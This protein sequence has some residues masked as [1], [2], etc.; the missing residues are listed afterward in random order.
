[1][2]IQKLPPQSIEAEKATLGCLLLKSDLIETSSMIFEDDFI[3]PSHRIIFR[4]IQSVIRKNLPVDI[5]TVSQQLMSEN[6]LENVG[7]AS[8]IS[9]LPDNI[10][11]TNNYSSYVEI[12]KEC[13]LRRKLIEV[14]NNIIAESYDRNI[15]LEEII[16]KVEQEILQVTAFD[17]KEKFHFLKDIILDILN[18][19]ETRKKSETA[20]TGIP[21]GYPTLDKITSGFEKGDLIIIAARPSVGKTTFAL[22]LAL[23]MAM[24]FDKIVG[25]FS[26]EMSAKMLGYKIIS[27]TAKISVNQI[28]K[29]DIVFADIQKL[30]DAVSLIFEKKI[31]FDEASSLTLFDIKQR[32]RRLKS[33]YGLDAIFVDYLQLISPPLNSKIENR[34]QI[35]SDISKGLKQLAK[36]L[37]I[38]VIA[39]AQLSRA[40]EKREDKRPQLSDLRESG[41][42]EQ[43]ADFVGFLYREDYYKSKKNENVDQESK[44]VTE[45]IIGKQRLGR[46]GDIIKFKFYEDYSYFE[47]MAEQNVD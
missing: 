32:A 37:E 39:C 12:V 34:V 13:A 25:F 26:L 6:L 46:R 1:M 18:D 7:G 24:N 28:R 19:M 11:T 20:Y 36:E 31:I 3:L 17:Y 8:Y 2:S 5:L 45:F 23:N 33:K 4:S 15:E 43:D 47:E 44:N 40:P 41:S 14:A 30:V 21:S 10:P 29:G 27:R 42:I 38:P 16:D 9:S 35:V 22:N